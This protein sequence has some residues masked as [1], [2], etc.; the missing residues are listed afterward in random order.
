MLLSQIASADIN[1]TGLE[2][3]LKAQLTQGLDIIAGVGY[4]N[5][6]F[7]SYRNPLTGTDL[8]DNRVPFAPELTY[9][10]A[11]QYRS[12]GGIF[13]RAELRG[14]GKTYLDDANLVE[15]DPFALVNLFRL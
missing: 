12:P 2:F 11:V 10:L 5:S 14:F 13:A 4:V 9:N 15:Q 1:V 6:Q 7:T 8:S 3:E